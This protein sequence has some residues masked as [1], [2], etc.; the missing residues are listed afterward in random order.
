MRNITILKVNEIYI[1]RHV[2]IFCM[3]FLGTSVKFVGASCNQAVIFM[4]T[5]Y[6]F[7]QRLLYTSVSSF[8][9]IHVTASEMKHTRSLHAL[10]AKNAQNVTHTHSPCGDLT[11]H[12]SIRVIHD[13]I[14][15][16]RVTMAIGGSYSY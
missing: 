15:L 13:R 11:S 12:P 7:R 2:P 1:V 8:V 4:N 5:D 9:K 14:T 10:H 16:R 6:L 3:M